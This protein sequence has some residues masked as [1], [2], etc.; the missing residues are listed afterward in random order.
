MK[1]AVFSDTHGKWDS[2]YERANK[3]GTDI[4]LHCGDIEPLRV[5]EDLD[6]FPTPTKYKKPYIDGTREMEFAKYY[7]KGEVP[8]PTY[9]ISGNHE[10]W[11]YLF[12]YVEGP[13]KLLQNLFYLGCF[14]YTE[15]NGIKIAGFSKIFGEKDSESFVVDENTGEYK[16]YR[17]NPESK[18]DNSPKRAS[19]YHIADLESLVKITKNTNIDILL[20]HENPKTK[21]QKN[22]IES[23][24]G[25]DDIDLLIQ[26]L[27]P[28]Y[29]F[30]GHMHFRNTN[31]ERYQNTTLVNIEENGM[32]LL[33]CGDDAIVLSSE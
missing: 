8:I 1:I 33:E 15:I 5:K 19:H 30:C 12:K 3:S 10:N 13:V 11:N 20:L 22:N 26:E 2:M 23:E 29:A 24:Y 9:F 17:W 27:K 16:P 32:I 31:T 4:V 6:Y 18:R 14:G 28:K 21:W 25:T 7:E